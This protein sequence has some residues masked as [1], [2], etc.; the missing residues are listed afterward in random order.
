MQESLQATRSGAAAN[1]RLAPPPSP[2]EPP[3]CLEPTSPIESS[4]ELDESVARQP[5]PITMLATH[6][7]K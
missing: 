3:S 2:D 4:D 6:V 5:A 1:S 7:F